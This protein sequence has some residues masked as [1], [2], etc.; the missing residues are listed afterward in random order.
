MVYG[1]MTLVLEWNYKKDFD[2]QDI[3][4]WDFKNKVI[5]S[6]KAII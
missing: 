2:D 3:E 5:Y 1:V 4:I 6:M